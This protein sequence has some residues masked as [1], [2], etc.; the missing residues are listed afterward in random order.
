MSLNFLIEKQNQVK[1][2]AEESPA[3]PLHAHESELSTL[4]KLVEGN[5]FIYS[6]YYF[7]MKKSYTCKVVNRAL[8]RITI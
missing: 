6:I 8:V 4:L 3:W 1:R 7:R 5:Y 2:G